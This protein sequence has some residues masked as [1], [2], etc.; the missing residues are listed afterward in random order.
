MINTLPV[1]ITVKPLWAYSIFHLDKNIENRSKPLPQKYNGK[2]IFIH[3]AREQSMKDLRIV[4]EWIEKNIKP[5]TLRPLA[6]RPYNIIN[7]AIIGSVE[8]YAVEETDSP[9]AFPR[10]PREKL[11]YYGIRDP[12]LLPKPIPCKGQLGFWNCTELVKD[13]L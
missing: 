10:V 1:A 2:R 7:S 4:Y 12:I 8:L 11:F 6:L 3:S 9:W 13:F 5:F